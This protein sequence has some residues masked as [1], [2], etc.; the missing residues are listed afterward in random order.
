L[1]QGTTWTKNLLEP[2]FEIVGTASDGRK[3]VELA[4]SDQ[5]RMCGVE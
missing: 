2:E 1:E 4:Q 3:L 5:T